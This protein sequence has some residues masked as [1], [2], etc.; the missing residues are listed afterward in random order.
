MRWQGAALKAVS[1]AVACGR[2]L[3]PPKTG[4]RILT[5]HTVGQRAYR[6]HLNLNTISL[7]QFKAHLG[8]LAKYRCARADAEISA[9]TTEV[10]ITFD[11]GYADNLHVV[12]PLLVER[13]IPF[14]VFVTGRFVRE[15]EK[16][17]LSESELRELASLPGVCIGAHGDTHCDLTRCNEANLRAELKTSKA[18]L[19]D[20]LGRS[21]TT[22]AYPYGAANRRVRDAAEECGYEFAASS[23]FDINR[24]GR[25]AL[26]LNRSVVLKGDSARVLEQKIKGDW[27]WYR[28]RMTDPL[29]LR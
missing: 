10:A 5:Y 2:V 8:V 7:E 26:M 11:D 15:K 20:V 22:M 23:Y 25:D 16:G 1:L 28:F 4:L 3:Q 14:T 19:A 29:R 27:D 12:A 21:I 18:Y 6:D 9:D 17:F 13:N 24:V